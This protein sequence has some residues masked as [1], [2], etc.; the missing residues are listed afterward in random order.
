[1]KTRKQRT[2]AKQMCVPCEGGVARL[3]GPN[4]R[5]LLS[6]LDGEWRAVKGH[7]LEKEFTFKDFKQA[8]AFT[9][10]VG[11]LAERQGHHPDVLLAW[12]RVKITIWTHSV[13]GLT[14]N[15]FVLAAKIEALQRG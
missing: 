6:S 13:G 3:K 5:R 4:V 8:L 9:N 1:M 7:H 2:L 14:E 12:G 15:D 11:T 10:R